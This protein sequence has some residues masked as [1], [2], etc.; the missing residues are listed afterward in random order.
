MKTARKSPQAATKKAK[1]VRR[2]TTKKVTPAKVQ[3][4]ASAAKKSSTSMTFEEVM[5]ALEAAGSDTTRKTYT[6]HGAKGPMFGVNFGTLSKLQKRIR[7][8]HDLALRLWATTNVDARNLAMKIA[9]PAVIQPGDLD[10]WARENPMPMCNLYVASLASESPLATKKMDDWLAS[11]DV[12]V[13]AAG[14]TLVGVQANRDE[15]APDQTFTK[16]LDRIEKSIH[17]A[18]NEVKSAMNGALIAIGGR[19]AG[20]RK[21]ACAA[22]KR[23]G[24]LEVDH[25]DTACQTPD[26]IP[27]IDKLW[28]RSEGR[29]PSPA[30]AERSR[31]SMRTRC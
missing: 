12:K 20:L 24:K 30:A 3:S 27:Y 5:K 19:S 29:F 28:E 11:S 21:A 22:A 16:L 18:A 31:D 4:P 15:T 14:W 17:S 26:A 1:T 13:S 2:T 9:D 6:R 25:G 8:D 7:V 23:I 10:Q